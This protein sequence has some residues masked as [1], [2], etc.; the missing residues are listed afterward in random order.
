MD[1][2]LVR[3]AIAEERDETLWPDDNDRPL[4][5]KGVRRFKRAA[6]GITSLVPEVDLV[7][8]SP[9]VRAWHTASILHKAG[10]PEP[11]VCEDLTERDAGGLLRALL[12]HSDLGSIALVGHEPL[13]SRFVA[14][15]VGAAPW[16]EMR[17]GGVVAL[18]MAQPSL[19]TKAEMLFYL[20]P[21]VLRQID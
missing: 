9:A 1:I 14:A 16:A 7:L 3:H 18:R 4:T 12:K 17:K 5:A 19:A 15:S 11:Q 8:A 2:Y 6:R 10:W 13:L 20:P 21:R